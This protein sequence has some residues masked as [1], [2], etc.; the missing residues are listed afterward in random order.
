MTTARRFL[1]DTVLLAVLLELPTPP[2][3]GDGV[4]AQGRTVLLV[5]RRALGESETARGAVATVL[6]AL[7]AA[8][9]PSVSRASVRTRMRLDDVLGGIRCVPGR[10]CHL[11]GDPLVPPLQPD[12]TALRIEVS[13]RLK[14]TGLWLPARR[15]SSC[16]VGRWVPGGRSEG[17]ASMSVAYRFELCR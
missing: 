3:W 1:L 6:D 12:A 4:D 14:T 5:G 15:P 16:L 11:D 8:T 10:D 9:V 2:T 17:S 7:A 13:G